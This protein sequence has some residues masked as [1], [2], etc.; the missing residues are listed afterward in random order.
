MLSAF[1]KSL[2]GS[3]ADAALA[4]FARMTYAGVDP[5]II[6]R[7]IIAHA[8]E[9]V[10]LANPQ[11][12]L[13]AAAAA[14][15]LEHIGMPE[16]RL[17]M[18]QAIINVCESPKTNTVAKAMEAAFADVQDKSNEPVPTHLRDTH[19][20]GAEKLGNGKGYVYPHEYPGPLVSAEVPAR[21]RA[22]H[23][24]LRAG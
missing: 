23:A 18:A 24:V 20:S 15:A 12:M 2:R 14:Q 1:C 9:D 13:Q 8:S 5:R 10:G 7:R 22:R 19:Y 21:R 11:A 17:P 3:D 6:A 4:W 16:A